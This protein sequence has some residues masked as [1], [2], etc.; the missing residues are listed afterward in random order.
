MT[1]HATSRRTTPFP[2]VAAALV[3][4][5]W[6]I[7]QAQ[8]VAVLFILTSFLA[9]IG[10]VPMHWLERKRIPTPLAVLL[11][12]AAMVGL[13]AVVGAVVGA[14][15]SSFSEALPAYQARAAD[16]LVSFKGFL[17]TKGITLTDKAILGSINPGTVLTL[18]A[19][20]FAGISSL[21]SYTVLVLLTVI[22]ILLESSGFA[23]KLRHVRTFTPAS[24]ERFTKFADDMKRYLV[25]KTIINLV[26]GTLIAAWLAVLGVDF[27]ILWGFLAFLLNYIPNIGSVVA[28]V[29]P[30]ILALVQM[31]GGTALLTVGGFLAT[32]T[33][34]GNLLEPR[35]MGRTFGLSPL[36]IFVSMIVWAGLLG[37][38]GA[39]LCVPLTMTLK[40]ACESSPDTEWIAVLLGPATT[41]SDHPTGGRKS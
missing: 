30:S 36:V 5:L 25:V 11:V 35:I 39:L 33:I 4:I 21:L 7:N 38:V 26:T 28:A 2:L 40:L 3:I 18:T 19:G 22:F 8:S 16:L 37:L 34:V 1:E 13:L 24:L 10:R 14:S 17:A 29:P 20:V 32:G 12:V 41:P 23:G 27:P 6:G 9:L 31:G 15:L